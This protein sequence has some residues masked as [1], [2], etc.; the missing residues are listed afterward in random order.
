MS[1]VTWRTNSTNPLWDVIGTNE[2]VTDGT[3]T[4]NTSAFG[5]NELGKTYYWNVTVSDGTLKTVSSIYRFRIKTLNDPPYAPSDPSPSHEEEDVDI[6]SDLSWTGGDPD[7][8]DN[9]EYDIYFGTTNPPPIAEYSHSDTNYVLDTLQNDQTYY[10][11]IIAWDEEGLSTTGPLWE[12]KTEES[13]WILLTYDGFEHGWSGSNYFDG[14]NRCTIDG[15]EHYQ[16]DSSV[17]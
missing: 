1:W 10:W 3:Y 15:S 9:V 11:Q 5:F 12:F 6:E 4:M 14:G 16:G 2:S 17:R 8:S 13:S 7:P